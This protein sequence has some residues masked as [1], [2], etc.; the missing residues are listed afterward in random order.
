MRSFTSSCSLLVL[1]AAMV[2]LLIGCAPTGVGDP[3][4][5]EVEPEGGYLVSDVVLE[6]SSLQCRTRACLVFNLESFCTK[7][8]EIDSDCLADTF[9]EGPGQD[10]LGPAYCEANVQIGGP[11]TIGTYCVPAS[12]SKRGESAGLEE[13]E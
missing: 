8:C 2:L 9:E 10:G 1:P 13:P 11:A 4:T 5:P 7:R 6:T 12:A 3:C